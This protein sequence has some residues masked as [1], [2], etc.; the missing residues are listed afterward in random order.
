MGILIFIF[1]IALSSEI[2]S[3]W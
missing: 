3:H 2:V 1:Q